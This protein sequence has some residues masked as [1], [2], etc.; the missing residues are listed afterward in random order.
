MHKPSC[1]MVQRC[2]SIS[3]PQEPCLWAGSYSANVSHQLDQHRGAILRAQ[4]IWVYSHCLPHICAGKISASASLEC[5]YVVIE[6]YIRVT[7]F[8]QGS[9]R[10][11]AA[12]LLALCCMQQV[13]ITVCITSTCFLHN[14][15]AHHA[16]CEMLRNH[17]HHQTRCSCFR[18]HLQHRHLVC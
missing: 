18:T 12:I 3:L 5:A 17:I 8:I 2:D 16:S 14:S 9:L 11:A 15:I 13:I 7:S 6:C 4:L 10:T 1:C